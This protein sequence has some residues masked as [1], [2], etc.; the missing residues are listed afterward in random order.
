[1]NPIDA[2]K[3]RMAEVKILGIPGLYTPLRVNRATVPQGMYTYDFQTSEGDWA[4]PCLIA[5]HVAAEHFG[6]VITVRPIK[7]RKSDNRALSPK[8]FSF[9][10][11]VERFSTEEFMRKYSPS[12]PSP[13]TPKHKARPPI[14][15]R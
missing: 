11:G 6:T 4:R 14:P 15:D 1:M 10:D 12:R 3:E 7:L 13:S 2:T 9:G 5:R 8:D